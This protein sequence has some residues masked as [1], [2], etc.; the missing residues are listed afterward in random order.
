MSLVEL[1]VSISVLGALVLM[2]SNLFNQVNRAWMTGEGGT[3]RRRNSRAITDYLAEELRGAQVPI[4]G[5]GAVTAGNLQFI[6]NP[7]GLT[8]E[9][10]NADAVFWQ[11]PIAT[12]TSFGDLAAV[13]YF[14]KWESSG[15][16]RRPMLCRYFV[17]PSENSG[18]GVQ[19]NPN[20]LVYD[21]DP[22][23][24]LQ[25]ALLESL[26]QPANRAQGYKGLFAE[27]VL[28]LWITCLDRNGKTIP[29]NGAAKFDSREGYMADVFSDGATWQERKY[30]PVS[31]RVSLAQVDSRSANRLE[32]PGVESAVKDLG[33]GST[34]A[35]DFLKRLRGAAQTSTALQALL[36]GV[37]IYSTEVQLRNAL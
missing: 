6:V 34:D 18:T 14:V 12:E 25:P 29:S 28:G 33:K 31:V 3:E 1:L 30:L 24:W 32:V 11:A 8:P 19:R 15:T 16:G 36:P 13:G 27:N 4:S 17:N 37:R 26:V 22:K 2:L 35:D 9:Y 10:L 7:S 21:S 23:A 5:G 20:F